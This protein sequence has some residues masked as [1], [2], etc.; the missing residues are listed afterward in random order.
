MESPLRKWRELLGVTQAGLADLAGVNRT[1]ISDV[2][3]GHAV[4][5]GKLEAFL[6]K[7]GGD[8]LRVIAGHEQYMASVREQLQAMIERKG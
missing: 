5:G 3:N 4:L 7:T 8:A 6:K 1:H 2:E